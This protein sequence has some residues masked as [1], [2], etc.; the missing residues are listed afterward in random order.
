MRSLTT[1]ELEFHSRTSDVYHDNYACT[2]GQAIPEKDRING[3]GGKRRCRQC[4][5]LAGRSRVETYDEPEPDV[6]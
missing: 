3:T 2:V 1:Y 6:L 5:Q 4:T